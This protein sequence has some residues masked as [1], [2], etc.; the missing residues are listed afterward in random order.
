MRQ[1]QL[2]LCALALVTL[3][4]CGS[5]MGSSTRTPASAQASETSPGTGSVAPAVTGKNSSTVTPPA[6]SQP[7]PEDKPH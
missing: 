3:S 4:A 6:S 2:A 5:M 1:L 7:A